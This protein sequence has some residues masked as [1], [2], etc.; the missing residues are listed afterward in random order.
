[1]ERLSH[2]LE[3]QGDRLRSTLWGK[4]LKVNGKDIE[5]CGS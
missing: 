4:R 3:G 1:M 2:L 5:R